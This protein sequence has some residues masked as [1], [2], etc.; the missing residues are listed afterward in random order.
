MVPMIPMPCSCGPAS[1]SLAPHFPAALSA[2]QDEATAQLAREMA[3][4]RCQ[5]SL[6][7]AL[8]S[9]RSGSAIVFAH[10]IGHA[11]TVLRLGTLCEES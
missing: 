10:R 2:R 1:R 5:K 6:A 9:A 7:T 8:G 11:S 3:E 4:A